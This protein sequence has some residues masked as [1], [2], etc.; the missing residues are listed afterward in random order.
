MLISAKSQTPDP[1][2]DLIMSPKREAVEEEDVD[3]MDDSEDSDEG[4]EAEI[5][6]LSDCSAGPNKPLD[7]SSSINECVT[8]SRR[9]THLPICFA[10]YV[11]KTIIAIL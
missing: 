1:R 4:D 6:G 2:A 3:I 9:R 8:K 10:G 11:N 5:M 7:C